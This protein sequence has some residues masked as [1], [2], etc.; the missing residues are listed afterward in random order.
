M[1]KKQGNYVGAAAMCLGGKSL[2]EKAGQCHWWM[3]I[4]DLLH[5]HNL[6]YFCFISELDFCDLR[7]FLL[8]DW[9]VQRQQGVQELI[10]NWEYVWKHQT[11][12][13]H[14]FWWRFVRVMNTPPSII[15]V[16]KW[17]W[18]I[19]GKRWWLIYSQ[20]SVNRLYLTEGISLIPI[21]WRDYTEFKSTAH[22]LQ[23]KLK[24]WVCSKVC[25]WFLSADLETWESSST[26]NKVLPWKAPADECIHC[27]LATKILL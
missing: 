13:P 16:K 10:Q 18:N 1:M 22:S 15:S 6:L 4:R 5:C 17:T 21:W 9:A 7:S 26:I 20:I 23:D 2:S 24:S 12:T 3:H 14:K 19:W 11:Y 25:G 8:L 27:V